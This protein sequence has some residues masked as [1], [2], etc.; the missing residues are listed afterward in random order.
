[1]EIDQETY[2]RYYQFIKESKNNY[3]KVQDYEGASIAREI[4]TTFFMYKEI[5]DFNPKKPYTYGMTKYL[6]N[7]FGYKSFNKYR[8]TLMVNKLTKDVIR[9]FKLI[10]I[11]I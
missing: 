2:N 3:V 8:F 7:E 10:E 4:E 11:G 6:F 1:M 5:E 9:D